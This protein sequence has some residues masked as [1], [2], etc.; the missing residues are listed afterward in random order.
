MNFKIELDL[1]DTNDNK[2]KFDI[3]GDKITHINF[4]FAMVGSETYSGGAY[5]IRH[6]EDNDLYIY[7]T[8]KKS[9]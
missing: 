2:I 1:L 4:A 8:K 6:F 5:S 9:F 7:I 3:Q